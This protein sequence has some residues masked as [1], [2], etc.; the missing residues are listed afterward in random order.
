MVESESWSHNS[1][2]H[3]KLEAGKKSNPSQGAD[4]TGSGRGVV[5][6]I[7]ISKVSSS[8]MFLARAFSVR[9]LLRLHCELFGISRWVRFVQLYQLGYMTLNN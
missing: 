8:S 7:L 5:G 4:L 3:Q 9:F 1:L 2:R 6:A